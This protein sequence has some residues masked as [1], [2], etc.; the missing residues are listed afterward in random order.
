MTRRAYLILAGIGLLISIVM[1]V[2]R[3]I[4]GY[5]DAYYYYNA[6]AK[7]ADGDGL[8]DMYLWNYVNAPEKLPTPS[9]RYWMPFASIVAAVPMALLGTQFQVA[10]IAFVPFYIGLACLAMW[11]GARLGK[12]RRHAWVAG[13]SVLFG[14]MYFPFYLTTD[15]FVLFGFWGAVVLIAF[16]HG[17]ETHQWQWF[18]LAGLCSALA[19]WTRADGLLFLLV[20]LIVLWWPHY[21]PPE[22]D[23]TLR[24]KGK[25]S[26]IFL[27]SYLLT[28]LPLFIRNLNAF[29]SP[30]PTG[31][32][33]TAFLKGYNDL[34]SYPAEWPVSEFLDWGTGN[35]IQ[36]RL[37][38]MT[39]ALGTWLVVEGFVFLTPLAL[40]ALW[41]RRHEAFFMGV[42]WYALGLHIAMSL[43]FTYPGIRGGLFHSSAAL[44]PFWAAL[45]LVGLDDLIAWFAKLRKWNTREAQTVFG[46]AV[47]LLPLAIGLWALSQQS[48]GWNEPELNKY[49]ENLPENAR[50]MVNDPAEWY[51]YT[52]RIGVTLPDESLETAYEIARRY[53]IQYLIIDENITDPF[54]PLFEKKESPPPFLTEIQT[55]EEGV[56]VYEFDVICPP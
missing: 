36:S 33:G 7:L 20:G 44:L 12:S 30:L 3:D 35:V 39:G 11:Q 31:G 8:T 56:Q 45:G 40:Y 9:H 23:L 6:G 24:T 41:K 51:Y 17:R 22:T 38:G 4:P 54:V 27:I 5:T 37:E 21:G 46:T 26:V 34:F 49:V 15:T 32:I 29:G 1:I 25:N 10:A 16:G 28:M 55:F 18:A 19:H 2:L 52:E 43:V 47:L 14:G 50:L 42:I 48:Q 13:L 53:C